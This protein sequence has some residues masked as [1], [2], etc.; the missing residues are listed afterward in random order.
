MI[1]LAFL[2]LG[3][4][5]IVGIVY[6]VGSL[7]WLVI[8]QWRD[9]FSLDRWSEVLVTI[10]GNKLRT[11]LTTISVAWGVARKWRKLRRDRMSVVNTLRSSATSASR[12]RARPRRRTIED[13]GRRALLTTPGP[14]RSAR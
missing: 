12:S 4:G 3:L 8:Q 13:G 14:V 1:V 7:L 11:A 5:L 6:T 2:L 9:M 10:G